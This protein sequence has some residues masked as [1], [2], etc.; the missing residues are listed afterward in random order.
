MREGRPAL[1]SQKT[2]LL[3]TCTSWQTLPGACHLRSLPAVW[4]LLLPIPEL[5][6]LQGPAARPGPKEG[7]RGL[8]PQAVCPA[9]VASHMFLA[10]S[11]SFS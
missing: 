4:G 3:R 9:W 1:L 6:R 8:G 11:L 10:A 5:Q 7:L 2:D